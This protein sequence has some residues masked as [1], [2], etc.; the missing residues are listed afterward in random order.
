[1]SDRMIFKRYKMK[2]LLNRTQYRQITEVFEGRMKPDIHEKT[3]FVISCPKLT[4]GETYTLLAGD[5][6]TT[7]TLDSLV[8]S[9]KK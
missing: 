5:T 6:T 4:S 7:V 8:K 9:V 1:M 2:Y 3:P